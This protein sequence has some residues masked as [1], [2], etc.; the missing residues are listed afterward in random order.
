M[1]KVNARPQLEADRID[2]LVESLGVE[3]VGP[4]HMIFASE[5]VGELGWAE[6]EDVLG[7]ARGTAEGFLLAMI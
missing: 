6:T 1:P 3:H 5:A 2:G 7:S 4:A